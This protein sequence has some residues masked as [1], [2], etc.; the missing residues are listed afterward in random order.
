[1]NRQ[2][3]VKILILCYFIQQFLDLKSE[4]PINKTVIPREALISHGALCCM[5]STDSREITIIYS[6]HG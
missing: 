5:I 1:M 3:N 6:L 2:C 4:F